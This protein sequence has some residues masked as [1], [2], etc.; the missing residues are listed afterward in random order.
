MLMIMPPAV[1]A[2]LFSSAA[3]MSPPAEIDQTVT[4]N[5]QFMNSQEFLD[6]IQ[7]GA[8]T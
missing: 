1:S 3:A 8:D 5:W 7:E 6:A 4:T 2:T